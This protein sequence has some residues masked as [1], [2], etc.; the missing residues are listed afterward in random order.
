M[1]F[2]IG[3]IQDTD[4]KE[5][6][7]FLNSTT[8]TRITYTIDEFGS[9]RKRIAICPHAEAIDIPWY[10]RNNSH[11]FQSVLAW[12]ERGGSIDGF[13]YFHNKPHEYDENRRLFVNSPLVDFVKAGYVD[14]NEQGKHF[15]EDAW[16][17]YST[18]IESPF[19]TV[20]KHLNNAAEKERE[21]QRDEMRIRNAELAKQA[22]KDAE[23]R[24]ADEAKAQAW[25][26]AEARINRCK[27]DNVLAHDLAE[28]VYIL[29]DE[30]WPFRFAGIGLAN[31][32]SGEATHAEQEFNR[33]TG[34]W[35]TIG[36][37]NYANRRFYVH[38]V[39]GRL[40]AFNHHPTIIS[41]NHT[42]VG[43]G[44]N[45][46]VIFVIGNERQIL[47]LSNPALHEEFDTPLGGKEA[48]IKL[49]KLL[50][51]LH[52][53]YNQVINGKDDIGSNTWS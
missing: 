1:K 30:W 9:F 6:T 28:H 51:V 49:K 14:F 22:E 11:L 27:F 37:P 45:D 21:K 53:L 25:R 3:I 16:K 20:R 33:N 24:R 48:S 31:V 7:G 23:K 13:V 43:T 5:T 29:P 8:K 41:N 42:L 15:I 17:I 12:T 32:R 44:S 47:Y 52:S 2:R 38:D 36:R 46:V 35:E 18:H 4:I 40:P 26:E 19:Q 34:R 10:I 39:S 50:P